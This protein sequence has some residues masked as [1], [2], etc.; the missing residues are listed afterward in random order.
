MEACAGV[1]VA[2]LSEAGKITM[3]PSKATREVALVPY[4]EDDAEDVIHVLE[5]A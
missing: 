3:G 4:G 5:N 2:L 1:R